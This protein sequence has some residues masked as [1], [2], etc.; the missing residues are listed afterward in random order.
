M[1]WHA[2]ADAC[3]PDRRIL[4]LPL[5]KVRPAIAPLPGDGVAAAPGRAHA[6]DD[7]QSR[8]TQHE[9]TTDRGQEGQ[10]TGAINGCHAL[11]NMRTVISA[12]SD[13]GGGEMP[14][15]VGE[16]RIT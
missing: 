16:C 12:I 1:D 5:R 9:T 11:R 13:A 14:R 7:R 4:R 8:I 3:Q 15:R 10:V 6:A 2:R